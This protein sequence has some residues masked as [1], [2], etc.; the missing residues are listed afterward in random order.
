[1]DGLVFMAETCSKLVAA[2][3]C[4][5]QYEDLVE[6]LAREGVRTSGESVV[7]MMAVFS[8]EVDLGGLYANIRASL[9]GM[10]GMREWV[11]GYAGE[12]KVVYEAAR[13]MST[14]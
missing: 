10:M 11:E 12:L 7:R 14:M 6:L 5:D 4:V 1:V 3:T 9:D 13:E 8:P 2:M